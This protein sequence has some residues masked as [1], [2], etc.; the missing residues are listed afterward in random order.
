MEVNSAMIYCMKF[1][2]CHNVH[3]YKNNKNKSKLKTEIKQKRNNWLNGLKKCDMWTNIRMYA[4]ICVLEYYSVIK[5]SIILS[6]TLKF[7]ELQNIMLSKSY[8]DRQ[9]YHAFS[10]VWK[11]DTGTKKSIIIYMYIYTCTTFFKWDF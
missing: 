10:Y 6:F 8:S 7:L 9:K 4:R 5:K 2:K 11:V 3:Q 1:S